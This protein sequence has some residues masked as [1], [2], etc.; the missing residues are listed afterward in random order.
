[1]T[2]IVNAFLRTHYPPNLDR[3]LFE[4]DGALGGMWR[5]TDRATSTIF[6]RMVCR[7]GLRLSVQ[8]HVGAYSRPRDD[9]ADCYTAVEIMGPPNADDLFVPY[10][11]TEVDD[12][13]IWAWVPVDVVAKVIEKHGG[14]VG[15][16]PMR[17]PAVADEADLP[18][19]AIQRVTQ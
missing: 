11:S 2:D 13:V 17:I 10:F 4:Y 12:E 15:A 6:P 14:L 1:M 18:A 9:F 5:Y 7:D 19:G 8:G 3:D 16:G